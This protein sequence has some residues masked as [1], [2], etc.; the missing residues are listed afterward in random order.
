M[1]IPVCACLQ[2][3][4]FDDLIRKAAERLL[5]SLQVGVASALCR[6][7]LDWLRGQPGTRQE[8]Q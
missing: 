7:G 4:V 6:S 1:Y 3:N 8:Q 5:E 2:P